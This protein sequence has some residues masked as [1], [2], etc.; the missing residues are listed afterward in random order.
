MGT[1]LNSNMS[2]AGGARWAPAQVLTHPSSMA[3]NKVS[4]EATTSAQGRPPPTQPHAGLMYLVMCD[5]GHVQFYCAAA[6]R[7]CSGQVVCRAC[8]LRARTPPRQEQR[9]N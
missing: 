2:F 4:T 7:T 1:S 6:A 9:R 8:A 5:Y 3:R